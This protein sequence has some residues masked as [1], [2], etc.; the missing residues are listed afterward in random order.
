MVAKVVTISSF[1]LVPC[2]P[3]YMRG[4]FALC[5]GFIALRVSFSEASVPTEFTTVIANR[6]RMRGVGPLTAFLE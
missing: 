5:Y 2:F 4:C 1:A 3:D 6:D